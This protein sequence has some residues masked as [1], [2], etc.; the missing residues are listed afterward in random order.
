MRLG[1]LYK[2]TDRSR[3]ERAFVEMKRIYKL[4]S[5]IVH[6]DADLDKYR[7]IDRDGVKISAIDAAVEHLRNT[8]A[9]LIKQPGL[10]DPK[11][12]DTFLLTGKV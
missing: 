8:F 12:I 10:L 1:G 5:K 11:K 6:G 4:R 7:E 3:A 2:V 9:A